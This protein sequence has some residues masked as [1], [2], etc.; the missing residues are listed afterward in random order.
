M[1]RPKVHITAPVPVEVEEALARD[2]DLS[3]LAEGAEGIVSMLTT[4]VD[5]AY[6]DRAGPQL[7]VVA[8]YAVG[9]NNVDL[10]AAAERNVVVANTPDVLT[11]AT[12][13]QHRLRTLSDLARVA[14]QLVAGLS[15]DFVGREDGLPGLERA[16]GLHFRAVRPLLQAVKYNALTSGAVAVVD[17]YSTD[18]PI[19]RYQLAV[20]EDDRRFFPPY[21]AAAL[22]SARLYR[23][24]P[25][26]MA[27]LSEL[28]GRI[29][30]A[31]NKP[32]TDD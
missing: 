18:G 26:A 13:E 4:R 12:A 11:R 7:R 31:M 8:N 1:A 2:F 32:N 21:E 23:D 27:A 19:A 6:L 3:P 9:V 28:S 25:N 22:V 14:P 5:A 29:D 24:E 16:Y 20:L 30:A 15:P 17:G 10:A